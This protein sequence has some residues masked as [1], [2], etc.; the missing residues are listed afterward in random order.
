MRFVCLCVFCVCSVLFSLSSYSC[1]SE[2][3]KLMKES[4]RKRFCCFD[5]FQKFSHLQNFLRKAH[6]RRPVVLSLPTLLLLLLL[7][8]LFSSTRTNA[9]SFP[10]LFSSLLSSSLLFARLPDAEK[11]PFKNHGT[12]KGND[13][14]LYET[15]FVHGDSE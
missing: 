5:S 7:L 14:E 13:E 8:Q 12:S 3:K 4:S 10:S 1:Y 9:S 11:E 6:Q 15:Y 2:S